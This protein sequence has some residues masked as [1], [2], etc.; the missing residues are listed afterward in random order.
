[1]DSSQDLNDIDLTAPLTIDEALQLATSL[2]RAG[3]HQDASEVYS[4]V[5]ALVPDHPDALHFMGVLAHDQRRNEDALR[6]MAR[7]VELVPKHAPFRNNFGNLLLDNERFE[8]AEREYRE[9]LA[10][11]PDRPD[12]LHNYAVLCKALR[13]YP[14]AE[15]SLLRA[16]E[17]APDFTEARNTLA[18]LYFRQGRI[19]EAVAQACEALVREPSN[20]FTREM[21]GNAHCRLGHPEKAAQIYR[22]WLAEE[23]DNPKALHHLAACTGDAIPAR[24]ADAYVQCIFDH[25]SKSFDSRLAALEYRAPALV[26]Q[27]VATC[28]GAPA[29]D[30][31][32]LDAGCGTGLC[33][34]LLKPFAQTLTG[35]DLSEGMLG[36]ARGR[37]LYDD[38]QQAE[39]CAYM[40]QHPGRYDII[41]SADTLV[42]FG[43]LDEAMAAAARALRPNGCLCFTVEA[44]EDGETQP[45]RLQH[46]GR[47]AHSRDYLATVLARLGLTVERL[48]QV[49]LRREAGLPVAGWLVLAQQPEH[50]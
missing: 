17:L 39:L 38:L 32:V 25:F 28:V 48:E 9:A 1:M 37:E 45:Y 33:A 8:D 29:A 10:L 23:P 4:R 5:L 49:V 27:A 7:S 22:E 42:Y 20:A 46:H 21:L 6:L 14:E 16:I 40:Q 12:A 36:K 43:V 44:L 2:H 41:V 26:A 19:E 31:A 35:V 13:R 11:D 15:R 18:G 50:P 34:A 24:A 3:H 47:Y 30:R